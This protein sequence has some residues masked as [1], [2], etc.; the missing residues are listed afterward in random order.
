MATPDWLA[1]TERI[2]GAS[3]PLY[4]NTKDRCGQ[5]IQTMLEVEHDEDGR[6]LPQEYIL[7]GEILTYAGDGG[8]SKVVSFTNTELV[9]KLAIVWYDGAAAP[10][11]K[12]DTLTGGDDAVQRKDTTVLSYMSFQKGQLT[13][14][15]VAYNGNTVTHYALILGIENEATYTGD[16]GAGSDPTWITSS[17]LNKIIADNSDTI[18]TD[19]I[20]NNV[21]SYIWD[22]FTHEHN[23]DGTHSTDPYDNSFGKIETGSFARTGGEQVVTMINSIDVSY[24]FCYTSFVAGQAETANEDMSMPNAKLET[25]AA[26]NANRIKSLGTGTFTVETSADSLTHYWLAIGA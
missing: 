23:A 5:T 20:A 22:K 3:H 19:N 21:E 26:F 10:L 24:L 12:T 9:P 18:S 15:N 4:A 6:H 16:T 8:S 11:E 17:T 7:V 25:V 2:V 14:K 13:I 1:A